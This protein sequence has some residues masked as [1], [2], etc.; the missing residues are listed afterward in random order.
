M[1]GLSLHHRP[2]A[3]SVRQRTCTHQ[4]SAEIQK[5]QQYASTNKPIPWVRIHKLPEY[6]RFPHMRHVNAGVTCQYCHGQIQNMAQ[7]Y[8]QNSL[9]MGWCVN[10]HVNGYSRQEGL[11]AAGYA[12]RDTAAPIA[13]APAGAAAPTAARRKARFDCAV[14]HY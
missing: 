7:V 5:L 14:C 12:A 1:H 13:S 9:N 8:Q 2:S 6:V 10:C 3:S 11:Q 4:T